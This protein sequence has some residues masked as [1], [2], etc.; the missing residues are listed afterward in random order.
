MDRLNIEEAKRD[1][2]L[3]A[4]NKFDN[5]AES[6]KALNINEEFLLKLI[7]KYKLKVYMGEWV[8]KPKRRVKNY[9]NIPNCQPCLFML[10]R[11]FNQ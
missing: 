11:S 1:N 2:L 3:R 10:V 6:A 7:N 9:T 4:L 8:V 5:N